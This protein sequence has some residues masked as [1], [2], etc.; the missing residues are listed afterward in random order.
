MATIDIGTS[1]YTVY[2]SLEEAD[3]YFNGSS[4]FDAWDVFDTNEKKRA[5]IS[6]TRLIDRQTW[7]GDKEDEDQTLAFP[8]I[9]LTDCAGSVVDE[10]IALA[11]ISEAS[12]ML[13]LDIADG[14]NVETNATTE[15]L[16]QTL[17]AGSVMITN[18][19][20]ESGNGTR[21]PLDV[22]ELIGCYFTGAEN[23]GIA[24][25]IA[26]GTCG[27]AFDDDFGFSGGVL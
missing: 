8:R 5:L 21:F 24:A 27:E 26:T 2:R 11:N 4:D 12:L 17:K 10:D 18:F 23:V 14:S 16:A 9:N 15:D 3:E 20:G 7:K 22:M 25:S 19:R 6:S 1:S 13:A